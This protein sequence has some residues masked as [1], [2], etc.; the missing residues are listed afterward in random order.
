MI[1]LQEKEQAKLAEI[2]GAS[3]YDIQ[4]LYAMRVLNERKA[5]EYII[6]WDYHR[7]RR[8]GKYKPGMII[9]RLASAYDVTTNQIRSAIYNKNEREFCCDKCHKIIPRS[10]Y[11]KNDGLCDSCKAET[12]EI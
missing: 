2:S 9:Q 1:Q 10:Q 6:R 12:I 11:V 4:K 7:I 8:L 5:V 3:I